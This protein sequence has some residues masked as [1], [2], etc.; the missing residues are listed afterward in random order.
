MLLKYGKI[1]YRNADMCGIFS[2]DQTPQTS[3]L[4]QVVVRPGSSPPRVD[5]VSGEGIPRAVET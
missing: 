2:V 3:A 1:A 4:S 5:R